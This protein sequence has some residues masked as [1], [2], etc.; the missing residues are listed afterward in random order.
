MRQHSDHTALVHQRPD[1]C[2]AT[3]GD[4]IHSDVC[5]SAFLDRY[6]RSGSCPCAFCHGHLP[7]FAAF[8]DF[9]LCHSGTWNI[10]CHHLIRSA[11][12]RQL[13]QWSSA[14]ALGASANETLA[15]I[16]RA[17][18]A[19]ASNSSRSS[20]GESTASEQRNPASRCAIQARSSA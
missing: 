19:S 3:A 20:G 18:C 15:A 5:R 17:C 9:V 1:A 10:D 8:A 4:R 6:Q 7:R 16:R 2:H 12:D 11:T 14:S 13:W